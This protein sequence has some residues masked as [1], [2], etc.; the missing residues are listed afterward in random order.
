M[1]KDK[2]I[3]GLCMT[4][5]HDAPRSRMVASL[6]KKLNHVGIKLIVFN[7]PFDFSTSVAEDNRS[8]E[9]YDLMNFDVIDALIVMGSGF[10]NKSLYQKTVDRALAK[11]IPV[12]L[13]NDEY[14]GCYQIRNSFENSFAALMNHVI[15]EHHATDTF[16]IAGRKGNSFSQERIDVYEKVLAENGLEFSMENVDYGDFWEEP[17]YRVIDDLL[18]TRDKLPQAIFCANDAMAMATIKRLRDAQIRVP[19]DVI[20]TGFDGS[21]LSELADIRLS[22]CESNRDLIADKF[23]TLLQDIFAG[24]QVEKQ[25]SVEFTLRLADSCG[26]NCEKAV[27]YRKMAMNYHRLTMNMIGHEYTVYRQIIRNMNTIGDLNAFYDTV[28]ELINVGTVLAMRPSYL[29]YLL[30]DNNSSKMRA[31]DELLLI[32][33][34]KE[35]QS[36]KLGKKIAVSV[37]DM[38]P[39]KDEWI[40]DSSIYVI[41][42]VMVG[43]MLCGY[44]EC[45][46][47]DIVQDSNAFTRI[48]NLINIMIHMAANDIRQRFIKASRKDIT[49]DPLTQ[50]LNLHGAM[51][52]FEEFTENPKN[53]GKAISVSVYE[54]PKYRFLFENYGI[55]TV[56]AALC[57]IAEALKLTNTSNCMIA[58]IAD[59]T[60][61]V[62]NYSDN[63]EQIGEII[64]DA[65]GT[66]YKLLEHYNRTNG[67]EYAIEVNV[68]CAKVENCAGHKLEELIQMATIE[69]YHNRTIYGTGAVKKEKITTSKEQ[70]ELFRTLIAKNL[71]RYHFQPIVAADTGEIIAYEALM[72]TDEKIGLNPMQVLEL[73]REYDRLYDVE[74]ATH[75]NV[76]ERYAKETETFFGRKVFINC[77]P[78]YSLK[79]EESERISKNYAEHIGKFVYEIT[80]QNTMTEH[81]LVMIRKIGNPNGKNAIAIDDF[82]TGHSNI[83]NLINYEPEIV[84]LDRFLMTDIHKDKSKQILVKSTI[85]FA[86]VRGIKVLAEGIETEE[87]LRKVIELGVDYIQ[88]YFTG[89][90]SYEPVER[91]DAQVEAMIQDAAKHRN[92][93]D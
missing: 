52:W 85:E 88:G 61:L 21:I 56:D 64:N 47:Y 3:V 73:A 32:S 46:S 86:K 78:G 23:A 30:S 33:S 38:I 35:K 74:I 93:Q 82:G 67:K 68:G 81:E 58:H 84:K 42:P 17:T 59:D 80:E 44:Y 19:Q 5:V 28:A 45:K 2:K 51:D 75:F 14:D 53:A 25:Q 26:C 12:I 16:F 31:D 57:Y 13:E 65:V 36:S 43:D 18:K 62:V 40:W 69:L 4:R 10:L 77:I 55:Y 91:I 71:F 34:A 48:L 60:F 15:R 6:H 37:A 1:I 90:P 66:F 54:V 24:K 27:D 7:N 20:V 83:S 22:T 92:A 29:S 89:R 72:R 87:E 9:I 8:A 39:M 41:N 49:I 11:N 70:Y 63:V 50:L 79:K 76:L